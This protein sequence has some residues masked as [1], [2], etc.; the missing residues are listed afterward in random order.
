MKHNK[1][2]IIASILLL[3]I[4]GMFLIPVVKTIEPYITTEEYIATKDT[5]VSSNSPDFSGET[6]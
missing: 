4:F 3:S 6:F 2:V 5:Y 1:K